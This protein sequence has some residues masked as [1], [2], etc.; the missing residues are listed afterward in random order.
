MQ[1]TIDTEWKP[2]IPPWYTAG[3]LMLAV[4]IFALDGT[5]ANVALPHMAGS[6]SSSRD[7]SMWI[8]TSY[9]IASGI[10]IPMVDWF[11]KVFG[12]KNFFIISVLL[13]TIASILCGFAQNL[14]FMVI[15]RVI[16]GFGGGGIIPI[17]QAIL[18]E[19]FPKEQRGQAMSMFGLGVITAPIIGPV[20][21][22]W[23]TDNWSWP[24]IFFI[25]VPFGILGAFLANKFIEDPPY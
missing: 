6:F 22:G 21:G 19:S 20:M 15:A 13:F 2:T 10:V 8:L 5:I 25:N 17:A 18:M 4:F 7:E 12:R 23:I 1:N 24:W 14:G 9:L 16:Q 11:S 3:A